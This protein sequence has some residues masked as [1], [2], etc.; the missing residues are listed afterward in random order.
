[1]GDHYVATDLLVKAE[2]EQGVL[3][4][5][6]IY[7]MEEINVTLVLEDFTAKQTPSI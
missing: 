7:Q 5:L 2:W 3:Q 6:T 1:M 4:A